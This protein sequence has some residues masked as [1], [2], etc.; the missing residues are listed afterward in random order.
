MRTVSLKTGIFRVA[1]F[2]ENHLF[3][4]CFLG[5]KHI[6]YDNIVQAINPAIL[7]PRLSR[8]SLWVFLFC[9]HLKTEPS[10]FERRCNIAPSYFI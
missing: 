4:A 8:S 1:Q 9:R 10:L 6:L 7:P 3:S 5:F 2:E